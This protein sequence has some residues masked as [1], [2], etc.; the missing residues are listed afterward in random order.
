MGMRNALLLIGALLTVSGC[1]RDVLVTQVG[2]EQTD[3]FEQVPTPKVDILWVIDNSQSTQDEQE[4]IARES[5]AFLTT[6]LDSSVD[7]QL[8]VI[9]T[10]PS[11]GGRLRAFNDEMVTGCNGCSYVHNGI[12]CPDLHRV[13]ATSSTAEVRSACPALAVFQNL[14]QVGTAGSAM[15]S[16]FDHTVMALGFRLDPY[17]GLPVLDENGEPEFEPATYNNRFLRDDADLMVIFVSDEDE[18]LGRTGTPLR[19]YERLLT[20]RKAATDQSITVASIVGWQYFGT[21]SAMPGTDGLCDYL[22]PLFDSNPSN[23][24]GVAQEWNAVLEAPS[25][26]T[27]VDGS[28]ASSG[29]RYIELSCRMGGHLANICEN[30]Y[31]TALKGLADGVIRLG[32]QFSLSLPGQFDRG[33]DCI[34]LTNDD[35]VLD[36][37]END[38]TDDAVDGAICVQVTNPGSVAE[39]V[40][41]NADSGW[42]Y[43]AAQG[44]IY[45]GG[46]YEPA[47]GAEVSIRYS[48]SG[49][50]GCG[51][52]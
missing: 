1:A 28:L 52:N 26:C 23:H 19:Y 22:A 36:C 47:P 16:A 24:A 38:S 35:P 49:G 10:D 8:G 9:T 20:M 3:V 29:M 51:L 11:E 39:Y 12:P 40:S 46:S 45:F 37:N 4:K 44:A 6:I 2:F 15:E 27:N 48:V 42:M 18:S 17:T 25:G 34:L 5:Q 50:M 7:F 30:D 21:G 31:Q 32:T 14:V 13:R 41:Q 43:D 33:E